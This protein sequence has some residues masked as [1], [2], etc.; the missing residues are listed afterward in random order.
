[1]AFLPF[2][3]PGQC[4][5]CAF[6]VAVHVLTGVYPRVRCA[7]PPPHLLALWARQRVP[8]HAPAKGS[9]RVRHVKEGGPR[10][11]FPSPP[12]PPLS[13]LHARIGGPGADV[14]RS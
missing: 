2:W 8:W 12:P 11:V 7:V 10:V 9:F 5:P 6:H 13:A 4:L 3:C 1:M 14:A